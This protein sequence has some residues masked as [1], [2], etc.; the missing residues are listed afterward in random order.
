MRQWCERYGLLTGP[1]AS[2]GRS[3]LS[4][5]PEDWLAPVDKGESRRAR[6]RRHTEILKHSMKLSEFRQ[7]SRTVWQLLDLYEYLA[8]RN[9]AAIL[10]T[11]TNPPPQ[12]PATPDTI[13]D[14]HLRTYRDRYTEGYRRQLEKAGLD[15]E[16]HH[17]RVAHELLQRCIEL[18]MREL[19]VRPA[20][21][22]N[23]WDAPEYSRSASL[24]FELH[25]K[26]PNLLAAIYL[27]LVHFFTE[28]AATRRCDWCGTPYP[29]TK[30][31]RR[32]CSDGCRSSGRDSGRGK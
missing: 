32:F 31:N 8:T 5:E 15:L 27:Q 23:F 2:S 25:P 1:A 4:L 18:K 6:D 9:G 11:F 30:S 12:W 19:D 3:G 14:R 16:A 22:W 28:Q 10:E 21:V 24:G 20:V 26:P 13:V 17:I 7:E 29:L